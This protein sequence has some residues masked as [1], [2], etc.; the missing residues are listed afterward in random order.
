VAL[1]GFDRKFYPVAKY[2]NVNLKLMGQRIRE[3]RGP[4]S[5]LV[6]S[7]KLHVH[8]VD[9]SRLERGE[10]VNPS[11]ELLL[12]ICQ[13]QDPP[14]DMKWLVSGEGNKFQG[15]TTGTGD[16]SDPGEAA[17][18]G[19]FVYFSPKDFGS[20]VDGAQPLEPDHLS[21]DLAFKKTWIRESLKTRPE[22]VVLIE[23]YCDSM[24][25]TLNKGD[26]ILVDRAVDSV[27]NDG[28]YCFHN[29]ER[30]VLIKRL[31]RNPGGGV[32][33]KSDN[34]DYESFTL[35]GASWEEVGIIGRVAWI[36]RRI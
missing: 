1:F 12:N 4:L 5:Q 36:G 21:E 2:K 14:I 13:L 33:V 7:G 10:T 29:N 6:Y 27:T 35:S 3:L 26:L 8:Q 28:L 24:K 19:D 32:V 16:R 22:D 11:P 34:P 31:Q 25:P 15:R 30:Q 20:L 9:I 17:L 18:D 23:A